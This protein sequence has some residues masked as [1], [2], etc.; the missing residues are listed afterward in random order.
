MNL[1][2]SNYISFFI[3]YFIISLINTFVI[4]YIP[5]FMLVILDVN[6][7]ELAFVQFLSYLTLFLG[8]FMGFFFDKFSNKKKKLI[9]ISSVF[10]VFSFS[11]FNLNIDNLSYFGIFLALNFTS[12][13]IIKSGMSKLMLEAS[14]QKDKKK[15]IILISNVSASFGS[16]VPILMFNVLI[17]D[18]NSTSLWSIFFNLCWIMSFPILIIFFLINDDL[19]SIDNKTRNTI[20]DPENLNKKRNGH[21]GLLLTFLTNFLIWSDKLIEFPFTSWILTKFGE[22]GFFTYSYL[23]F[24]FTYLYIGG[25]F[26][27]RRLINQYNSRTYISISIVLYALLIFSLIFSDL[28][29]FLLLTAANKVVSGVMM[30]QL[31]ERNISISKLSKNNALS[32]EIIRS[33]SLLASFIF[34]PLGTL[35][36]SYIP[37][38]NLIIIVAFMSLI[39]ITPIFFQKFKLY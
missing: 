39:S 26:I 2:K 15:N 21:I 14:E 33:S 27:S 25:W 37:I 28:T 10:L 8:P 32:Y 11:F 4:L 17:Y 19:V 30:S 34:V 16:I 36:S 38:E 24:I 3:V 1:L 6:R 35:L 31:T 12:R 22:S 7:I 29:T 13:L 23:F 5:V 9:L 20:L 18:I